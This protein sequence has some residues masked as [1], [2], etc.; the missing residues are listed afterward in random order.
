[1]FEQNMSIIEILGLTWNLML[2]FSSAEV[3]SLDL[4]ISGFYI[5]MNANYSSKGM[6][7]QN[8]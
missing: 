4:V 5:F 3:W 6:Y 2:K 8:S 1:M 7:E